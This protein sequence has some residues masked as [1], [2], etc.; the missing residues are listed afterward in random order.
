MK[1]YNKK[2]VRLMVWSL[3]IPLCGACVSEESE[4]DTFSEGTIRFSAQQMEMKGNLATNTTP[5]DKGTYYLGYKENGENVLNPITIGDGGIVAETG[6]Y[7]A[8]VTKDGDKGANFTLSNV[9]QGKEGNP[10][11]PESRDILWAKDT[12]WGGKLQFILQHLM[13]QVK[14]EL[15]FGDQINP[16]DIKSV[17]LVNMGTDIQFDRVGGIVSTTPA[18]G[19]TELTYIADAAHYYYL[20]PPQDRSEEMQLKVVTNKGKVYARKLPFAMSQDIGDGNREDIP[21]R[22]RSGYILHLEAKVTN[23]PDLTVFF[24]GATLVDWQKIGDSTIG[25]KPAGIYTSNELLEWATEYNISRDKDN[26][27]LQRYGMYNEAT[28]QWTFT[29]KR[30]ITCSKPATVIISSFVDQLEGSAKVTGVKQGELLTLGAGGSVAEN[31]FDK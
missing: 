2:T 11:I 30:D 19:E 5:A 4:I 20:L 1:I 31:I 18:K 27:H 23:N 9:G 21:L 3:L 29:L 15:S 17:Y 14:V 24:T 16:A 28:S 10:V 25:V 7:W 6:L 26:I 13:A 8:K 12:K 22:L